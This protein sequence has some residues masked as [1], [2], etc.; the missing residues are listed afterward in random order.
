M[1]LIRR[2]SQFMPAAPTPQLPS[3][4]GKGRIQRANRWRA[5]LAYFRQ[6][7]RLKGNS[8]ISV[9]LGIVILF[10]CIVVLLILI[11]FVRHPSS[12]GRIL[13][14]AGAP[15]AIRKISEEHDK[16][17][18]TG[19]LEPDTSQ[20]RANGAFVVLARNKELEGVIQSVKSIERHFNRWYHY[21]YVFLNDGDFNQTFK[22]V[23]RNFTSG[24]VEFGKVG[25]EMWGYPDWIDP[26]VAKEGIA[27]QGDAAVMYGGLESYHAMCRFYSGFF[28]KHPLLAKYEWYWRLEPEIKYFCDITYDPFLRMIESN[29]TYGFTIAVKELRETVPNMFRYA[30]AYKRQKNLDSKG[31]WE[32]FVEPQ[33]EKEEPLAEDDPNYKLPLP[34]EI[35]RTDPSRNSPPE[36]DPE[37]MEGEKYNMC[38]FW[39]NFEIARLSFF[40]SNEYEEFFQMMD[41]SGG[42]WMERWG[43]API[44][45]LAAGV[46]LAPH[47]IHY[48]RDFGYRHTTIQHCPANAPARQLPRQPYLEKTTLDERKR[49]E[50]DQ[51]WENY[52]EP[53]ENGVGCRCRCDTDIVDVEGKEGSCLAEWV[54]VAGGWASP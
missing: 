21:P 37:G 24:E 14:P 34:E 51:Y 25:P 42:F 36:I 8:N 27:K 38:H 10:P 39:S 53:K 31:L 26:K 40:R 9:P 23:I 20:P 45:S 44:H 47:D 33:P 46:L 1:D 6:P 18:V 12:P 3:V 35:L 28:Y 2:A 48:F 22:D 54:D 49:T 11:L 32:M 19:C 7:M 50:E 4:D 17:F 41:R 15:P 30:S 5:R 43:D 16:V 29:K 52:D 13:M